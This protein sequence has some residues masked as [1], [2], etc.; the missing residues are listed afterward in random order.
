MK[1]LIQTSSYVWQTLPSLPSC[2]FLLRLVDGREL[3]FLGKDHDALLTKL[4]EISG[5]ASCTDTFAA[6]FDSL[7]NTYSEP[8]A[9]L[10]RQPFF[11]KTAVHSFYTAQPLKD[12]VGLVYYGDTLFYIDFESGERSYRA[13]QGGERLRIWPDRTGR[14]FRVI[15]SEDGEESSLGSLSEC[16]DVIG[17][18]YRGELLGSFLMTKSF[19]IGGAA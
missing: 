1:T 3:Q 2:S 11:V 4:D 16:K 18:A 17:H 8:M 19:T 7:C 13:V 12:F 14:Y 15:D 5:S 10:G 9:R 6:T